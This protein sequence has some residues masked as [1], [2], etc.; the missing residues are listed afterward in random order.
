MLRIL[1]NYPLRFDFLNGDGPDEEEA[2]R[3]SK[4]LIIIFP[5]KEK[6]HDVILYKSS[7]E[8]KLLRQFSLKLKKVVLKLLFGLQYNKVIIKPPLEYFWATSGRSK[9]IKSLVEYSQLLKFFKENKIQLHQSI[10][11]ELD[12]DNILEKKLLNLITR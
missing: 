11:L 9:H 3:N 10:A 1:K 4:Q 6:K 7:N 2:F 5:K 12:K 8:K